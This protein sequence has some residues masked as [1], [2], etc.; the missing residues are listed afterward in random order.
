MRVIVA[1][2]FAAALAACS[3]TPQVIL[4]EGVT[5]D[6]E[7]LASINDVPPEADPNSDQFDASFAAGWY[8]VHGCD[9]SGV[10]PSMPAN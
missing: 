5:C 6:A 10:A 7:A 1:L 3:S 4:P 8:G 9:V 2:L